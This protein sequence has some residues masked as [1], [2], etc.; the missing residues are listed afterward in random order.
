VEAIALAVDDDDVGAV[1]EAVDQGDYARRVGEGGRPFGEGLVGS[2]DDRAFLFM[3]ARD[4]LEEQVGV[5]DVVAPCANV[6]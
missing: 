2:Q 4:D 1:D 6:P 3:S 5:P